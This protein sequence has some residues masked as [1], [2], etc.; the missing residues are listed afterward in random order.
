MNFFWWRANDAPFNL[1][2]V[3]SQTNE[4]AFSSAIVAGSEFKCLLPLTQ[5]TFAF[6]ARRLDK[7]SP[8][9][10][11]RSRSNNTLYI[12]KGISPQLSKCY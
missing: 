1:G 4:Y 5:S 8:E 11:R 3:R 9:R 6:W 10:S 7:H 2:G 12:Q